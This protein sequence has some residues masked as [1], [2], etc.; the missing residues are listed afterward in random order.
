MKGDFFMQKN[1]L[2]KQTL[3]S[4][5]IAIAIVLSS[6][7]Q[8]IYFGGG[9]GM[10]IGFSSYISV[11]PSL[12]FGPLYGAVTMGIMDILA[13]LIKPDG[14]FLL[15][16]TITAIAGGALRGFLWKYFKN[17]KFPFYPSVI[18]FSAFIAFGL[19]NYFMYGTETTYARFL[20]EFGDKSSFLTA[21]PICF[22]AAALLLTALNSVL[23]KTKMYSE[24]FL[25][26]LVVLMIS[27]LIV[28]T[29]NT[30]LLMIFVPSLSKLAFAYFYIPRLIE[31]VANTIVQSYVVSYLLKLFYKLS[32]K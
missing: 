25:N 12:L 23:K 9:A 18:L 2:K 27:N 14:G 17:K 31:E 6:F 5:F 13:F 22:G 30:F 20:G 3:T 29:A 26:V 19:F 16:I 10:R 15:P 7:S 28:T 24:N 11:L 4:L 1:Q 32:I 21:L 8:M